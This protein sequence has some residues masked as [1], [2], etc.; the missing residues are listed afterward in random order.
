VNEL[1]NRGDAIWTSEGAIAFFAD[2]L[3]VTPDS[4]EWPIA[5]FFD[6]WLGKTLIGGNGSGLVTPS[7][8]EA[9][10]ESQQPK[11]LVFIRNT[12]WV[13]YPDEL[14]WSGYENATGVDDFVLD[15]YT[16]HDTV[17]VQANPYSYEVWLRNG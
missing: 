1:T 17:Q 11:V 3:I 7:E 4:D 10:W 14:L 15:H 16:L 6:F 9:S 2:R 8:F 5:G 12:G 13:P